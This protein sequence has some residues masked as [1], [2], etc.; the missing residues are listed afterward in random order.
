MVD[1]ERL[2]TD[3]ADESA[4]LDSLVTPLSPDGWARPTPAVG[5]SVAHQIAHLAWTDRASLIA[6]TDAEAFAELLQAAAADPH[7]FVDQG[8]EEF[9]RSQ[10]S[11]PAAPAR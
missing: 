10:A 7:K 9:L 1:L 5:W 2:L 3:L 8:A 6:A 4:V 11:D